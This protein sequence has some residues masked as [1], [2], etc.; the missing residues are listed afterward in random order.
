MVDP[1]GFSV[2]PPKGPEEVKSLW[3]PW[4]QSL[5]WNRAEEDF[6]THWHSSGGNYIVLTH[7]DP[8][9]PSS[10]SS[11]SPPEN[12]IDQAKPK[13]KAKPVGIILPLAYPNNTGWLG[14]FV[15]DAAYRGT[16]A[17]GGLL[18]RA[19]LDDLA[20][21]GARRVGLD[22]VREQVATY[23]RRGFVERGRVKL[24]QVRAQAQATSGEVGELAAVQQEDEEEDLG[25]MAAAVVVKTLDE[26]RPPALVA[27]DE[28]VT[29][30]RRTGL[31]TE[32]LLAGRGDA[33]GFAAVV[34]GEES[35]G[36]G[37]GDGRGGDERVLG[38]VLVRSCQHGYRVGPLYAPSRGWARALL[39]RAMQKIESFGAA[40]A[41]KSLVAEVW[42]ENPVAVETFEGLG[43]EY[44]GMDYSR[45][46][47]N[48]E[49]TEA[50]K[51][52]GLAEKEVFAWFDA[53]EG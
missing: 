52:G 14:F 17:G 11:P 2:R 50:Q 30:L 49:E 24:M 36:G 44:S 12:A 10:S 4:M 22:G 41:G 32:E 40:A 28:R 3:W 15:V 45:M 38:F 23:G 29:G 27:A 18:F 39:L 7:K 25:G 6:T 8:S 21:R 9:S 26:V 1:S 34:G 42:G 19:A 5:G 51:K 43:W 53:G 16:G 13:P 20:R 33:W 48:G 47:L 46:W 37:G 31:W 35:G